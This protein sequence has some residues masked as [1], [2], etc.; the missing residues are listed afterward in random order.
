MD[1]L[2]QRGRR[3]LRPPTPQAGQACEDGMR[4][5]EPDV[6]DL[7]AIAGVPAEGG[8]AEPSRVVDQEQDELERVGEDDEVKLGGGR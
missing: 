2:G 7:A 4:L 1:E 6:R 5:L 3:S 8:A